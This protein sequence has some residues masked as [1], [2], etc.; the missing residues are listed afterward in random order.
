LFLFLYNFSSRARFVIGIWAV[1]L[2]RKL[3]NW[4]WN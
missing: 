1:K 3:I 2:A 4:N